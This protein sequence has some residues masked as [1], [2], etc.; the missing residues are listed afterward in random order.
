M[1]NINI[2]GYNF[3]YPDRDSDKN[4]GPQVTDFAEGIA[5]AVNE[6]YQTI[7][8][9]QA[10]IDQLQATIAAQ[11]STIEALETQVAVIP[12]MEA[13][14]AAQQL[15]IE[16]LQAN[17]P[18]QVYCETVDISTSIPEG[19]LMTLPIDPNTGLPGKYTVGS[20]RLMVSLNGQVFRGYDIDYKEEGTGISSQIK[21]NWSLEPGDSVNFRII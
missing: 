5:E 13:T 7:Q 10:I 12:G 9:Q 8:D 18:S 6:D 15:E 3:P 20:N 19:A 21:M 17:I 1:K 4:W 11:T 14:I 2:K 16:E